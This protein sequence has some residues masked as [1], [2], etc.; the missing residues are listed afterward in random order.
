MEEA[1]ALILSRGFS[2]LHRFKSSFY[3]LPFRSL[4]G[5][6]FRIHDLRHTFGTTL[7][8]E[9]VDVVTIKDLMGHA[10]IKT[11]MRYLHAAPDRNKRAVENLRLN[12]TT[13]AE[14]DCEKGHKDE[15]IG[16]AAGV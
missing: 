2:F 7:A 8:A 6:D 14:I 4:I 12:G 3:L 5:L 9:G 15:D 10:N 11:T 1:P 13:Q 16:Q